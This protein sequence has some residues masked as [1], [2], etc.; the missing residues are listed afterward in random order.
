MRPYAHGELF[1]EHLFSVCL[2]NRFDLGALGLL[3]RH[4]I[5]GI[6]IAGIDDGTFPHHFYKPLK[7]KKN[8]ASFIIEWE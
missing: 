8:I 3:M 2:T 5:L 1:L 6:E 7:L 4:S